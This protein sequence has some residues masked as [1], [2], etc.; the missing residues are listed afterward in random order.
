MFEAK[1]VTRQPYLHG[2]NN[3]VPSPTALVSKVFNA[4]GAQGMLTVYYLFQLKS[5]KQFNKVIFHLW[6]K[7]S[8]HK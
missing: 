5:S 3:G 6:H 4:V 8:N 7:S 1:F 2:D